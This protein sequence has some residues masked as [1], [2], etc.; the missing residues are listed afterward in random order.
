MPVV[1]EAAGRRR[2]CGP[3]LMLR[4]EGRY[5]EWR[6]LRT[7]SAHGPCP[8]RRRQL[9]ELVVVVPESLAAVNVLEAEGRDVGVATDYDTAA[10]LLVV[11]APLV[12]VVHA[13]VAIARRIV[14]G[15]PVVFQVADQGADEVRVAVAAGAALCEAGKGHGVTVARGAQTRS[16][17]LGALLL[18]AGHRRS[19]GREHEH[20]AVDEARE[21]DARVLAYELL[22]Q[23]VVARV[24]SVVGLLQADSDIALGDDDD[25][26]GRVLS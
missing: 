14:K 16:N 19:N 25:L 26:R 17:R 2:V 8:L 24:E 3:L 7:C 13:V 22:Q 15:A 6:W 12:D 23:G 1:V 21:V 10:L 20:D 9:R 5:C 11:K 4:R 18:R